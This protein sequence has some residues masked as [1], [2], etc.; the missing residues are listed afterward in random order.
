MA[1]GYG[2]R[3]LLKFYKKQKRAG[4]GIKTAK[5]TPKTGP[6][7]AAQVVPP[8]AKE[9]IAISDR[10]TVIRTEVESISTLGRATQGV[11]IMKVEPGDRV[12]SATLF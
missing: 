12:S 11:R 2:K 3:T 1:N 5:I 6:I 4:I 8:E 7:V 10:G 9:I